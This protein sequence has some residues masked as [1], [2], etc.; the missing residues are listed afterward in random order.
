[1]TVAAELVDA[2]SL[3][4]KLVMVEEREKR[5]PRERPDWHRPARNGAFARNGL[6]DLAGSASQG[7]F[8]RVDANL[9]VPEGGVEFTKGR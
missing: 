2:E 1:M 8:W 6:L 5:R 4:E 9:G 7:R 3:D